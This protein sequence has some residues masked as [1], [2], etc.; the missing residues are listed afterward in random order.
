MVI[1]Y[2]VKRKYVQIIK[3]TIFMKLVQY[4]FKNDNYTKEITT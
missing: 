1:N 4:Q 2:R 3:T